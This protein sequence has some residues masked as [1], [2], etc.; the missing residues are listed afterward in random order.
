MEYYVVI[1]QHK[2]RFEEFE[3]PDAQLFEEYLP[4]LRD[5][6]IGRNGIPY[7]AYK[8]VLPLSAH[9]FAVHNE[10][11]SGPEKPTHLEGFNEQ[12]AQ[13]AFK[14]VCAEDDLAAY[15]EAS[16]LRTIFGSIGDAKM[17]AGAIAALLTPGT[18]ALTPPEQRGFCRGRQL[19]LNVVDLDSY[20]PAFNV[21]LLDRGHTLI[22]EIFRLLLC[23]MFVIRF[24]RFYISGCFW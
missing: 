14:G 12:L 3:F 5:F 10:H 17:I 13:F 24:Q 8:S 6:A 4:R 23:M 2:F 22:F 1:K 16:R 7:S 18:L 9:P 21:M 20:T 19:A 11:M 15:R